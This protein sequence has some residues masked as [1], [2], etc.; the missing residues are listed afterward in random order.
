[1]AVAGWGAGCKAG[2][3]RNKAISSYK[4][5][6]K[7]KLKVSVAKK[8]EFSIF[9]VTPSL[10]DGKFLKFSHGKLHAPKADS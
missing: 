7:L 3:N 4:L 10:K 2:E 1:M 9:P 8:N 5:K 6:L